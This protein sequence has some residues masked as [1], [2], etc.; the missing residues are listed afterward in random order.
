MEAHGVDVGRAGRY[1]PVETGRPRIAEIVPSP[2]SLV[3]PVDTPV[4]MKGL[5]K[6]SEIPMEYH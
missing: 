2:V 5:R 4:Y 6:A 3:A 1:V